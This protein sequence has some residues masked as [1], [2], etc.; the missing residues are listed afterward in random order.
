[1]KRG[2]TLIQISILL[3]IASLVLVTIL[4]STRSTLDKNNATEAKLNSILL[5][6]RQY[7][8]A[9]GML[10]CPAD[11]SQP[12]D[13]SN[14]GVAAANSGSSGNCTGGT[15]AANY[16]DAANHVAIGMVPVRTL[17]LS[18]DYALDAYGRDVTYAV[19]TN[20][21]SCW[22]SS[23][24]P[25][26]LAIT[27]NGTAY[28]NIA[29]LLSHGPDGHGAWIP[30]TGSGGSAVRLNA[31]STDA[32][33]LTNAHVDA[34]FNPTSTLTNFV[35]KQP[36]SAFDDLVV[37][38]SS[39]WSLNALPRSIPTITAITPPANGTYTT[40]QTLSFTV[41]YSSAVTVTTTGGTPYLSL[42]AT[43]GSVGTSNLAQAAYQSGSGST[44]LT[45]SYTVLMADSAPTGLTMTSSVTLNGGS[46]QSGNACAGLGFSAP[47]LSGVK[48]NGVYLYVVDTR[49]NRVQKLD[50]TG[51]FVMGIGAG[52][53]G[54]S[55][56]IGSSGSLNGQFNAPQNIAL[57]TSGNIWVTDSGNERAQE[58]NSSGTWLLSIGNTQAPAPPSGC[59]AAP[60]TACT[61]G[62]AKGQFS[63]LRGITITSGG[64]IATVESSS[65]D[66]VQIFNSS[67][68][69]QSKFSGGIDQPTAITTDAGG[70]Y[71]ISDPGNNFMMSFVPA[72]TS[73][74]NFGAAYFNS[75]PYG[76]AVDSNGNIWVTD[77][78]ARLIEFSSA[79]SYLGLF[80]T[81]G[82]GR[83]SSPYGVATDNNNNIWVADKGNNRVVEFNS[84]GSYVTSF[85]SVG[86]AN[87][88]FSNPEGIAVK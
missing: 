66:R 2:F 26:Q 17:G 35:R 77:S 12:V 42:S 71:L 27:D 46:I 73:H 64:S 51:N 88:Q 58:F 47:D 78:G 84:S 54:V 8:A 4:P 45:F 74:T 82:V 61:A 36:T 75:G 9:N 62:S 23:V 7:H 16:A 32:D 38:K 50:N 55:G 81:S 30:R 57:D 79:Y 69:Y 63:V 31:G 21:T 25:G 6:L 24:L 86:S 80:G 40:G 53:N 48:I 5:T 13:A 37:Y 3:T 20:A 52:Y 39:A 15:P 49:N 33:Q 85:G 87:G 56:S 34:S 19:D 10:P 18:K 41:T 59:T 28:K 44:A 68:V 60:G 72:G 11:A 67:G 29:A 83:L 43:T 76:A 65:N 14:Y 1:M 70:N 22:T